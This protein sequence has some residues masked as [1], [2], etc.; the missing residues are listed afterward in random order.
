MATRSL[1][2]AMALAAATAGCVTSTAAP[3]AQEEGAAAAPAAG[4]AATA[5]AGGRRKVH[6]S[7]DGSTFVF[8]AASN[9]WRLQPPPPPPEAAPEHGGGGG[10][11]A[12][13]APAPLALEWSQFPVAF[14]GDFKIAGRPLFLEAK[15]AGRAANEQLHGDTGRSIWDGAIAMAKL[16]EASPGL[17]RGRRVLE[18]GT[19]RGVVGIAAA[20]LG[21]SHTVL[22]DLGYCLEGCRAALALNAASPAAE[23]A[24]GS[25]EVSELDWFAPDRFLDSRPPGER[26]DIIL[27][28]DVVW[29]LDLTDALAAAAA[30]VAAR[31]PGVEASTFV[32]HYKQHWNGCLEA[33]VVHQLR[34]LSVQDAFLSAMAAHGFRLAWT[35]PGDAAGAGP[36]D[37]DSKAPTTVDWHPDFRPDGRISLWCFRMV[38][39]DG[40]AG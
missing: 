21:A 26:F 4:E 19:G 23:P 6:K 18:L 16:L 29:L 3:A 36:P 25:L 32:D 15:S 38:S 1:I 13:R 17:V 9:A 24:E 5:G 37:G 2:R 14:D 31:H 40:S 28:A 12:S 8:D 27:A 11:S 39:S 33:L 20:R 10:S 30:S 34:S 22:T 35:L 7:K